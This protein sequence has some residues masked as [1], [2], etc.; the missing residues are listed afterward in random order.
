M[1]RKRIERKL[2]VVGEQL[3]ALRTEAAVCGEQ[4]E[5]VV[6][7]ADEARLR[8]LVSETPLDRHEHREAQRSADTLARRHRRVLARVAELES[9][10]D[11]L[12]D[13]M[14]V[15]ED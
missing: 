11:R 7:E 12:L 14:G 6:A 1:S 5:Q 13:E 8:A 10:Q 4:L 2:I 9:R 15:R 3:A